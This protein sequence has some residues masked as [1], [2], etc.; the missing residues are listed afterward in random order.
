[1]SSSLNDLFSQIIDS[2][3][4]AQERKSYLQEVKSKIRQKEAD[5]IKL[6]QE[7][8][9]LQEELKVKVTDLNHEEINL[10]M[11]NNKKEVLMSQKSQFQRERKELESQLEHLEEEQLN[12]NETF[13]QDV[14]KFVTEFGLLGN[15]A[16]LRREEALRKVAE[17]SGE[18]DKLQQDIQNYEERV[19]SL[20]KLKDKEDYLMDLL[21][22]TKS[23]HLE[24]C[25]K[26]AE[27]KRK[28]AKQEEEKQK[29]QL[30]PTTDAEFIRLQKE[31]DSVKD[32]DLERTCHLLQQQV[33]AL[34]Q[35]LWQRKIKNRHQQKQQQQQQT[36]Y[37]QK[38]TSQATK[39][40]SQLYTH[41]RQ[42]EDALGVSTRNRICKSNFTT[43]TSVE[44]YQSET[45][46]PVLE[47]LSLDNL[48][49]IFDDNLMN[50]PEQDIQ[51][52]PKHQIFRKGYSTI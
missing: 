6:K 49:E 22:T 18:K 27:E 39:V 29:I 15:G 13:C 8:D 31:I 50:L 36:K 52:A 42:N 30:L 28:L 43:D 17:L 3:R 23:Q 47:D 5:I 40:S 41:L 45:S 32:E 33:Q 34:Q 16:N 7:K 9:E 2:E 37:Q 38:N 14:E 1:M 24:L 26:V 10:M 19:E 4:R 11:I 51:P 25:E 48:E 20:R 21:Q 46:K 35:Q 12:L 44:S